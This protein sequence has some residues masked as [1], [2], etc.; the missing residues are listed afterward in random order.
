[1]S[2]STAQ[3]VRSPSAIPASAAEAI[4]MAQDGLRWLTAEPQ[5]LTTAELADTLRGLERVESMLT[6]ARAAVLAAFT[7]RRGFAD[8]GHASPRTWL[9]WQAQVTSGAAAGAVGWM[10]RL[11]AHPAVATA[12]SSGNVSASWAREICAWS[13]LVPE[14]YREASDRILLDAAAG[15]AELAD[16]AGLAAE[17]RARTAE[18]DPGEGN[19]GFDERCLGL[20]R[21]LDGAGRLTGDLTPR[22]AAALAAVLNALGKKGGPEDT[23]TKAQRAHDAL[24]EACRRLIAAGCLPGRAGQP[25][26]IQLHMRLSELRGLPGAGGAEAAWMAGR[27]LS[28][29]SPGDDC[30]AAVAPVVTGSIDRGLLDRLADQLY[31][32]AGRPT[33]AGRGGADVQPETRATPPGTSEHAVS[34]TANERPAADRNSAA[35]S[36]PAADRGIATMRQLILSRAADVLSGPAGLAAYLRRGLLDG[37]AAA[38]SLPLDVGAVTETIPAH[39]RRAVIARDGHCGFPGCLQPAEVC[40]VHHIVPRSEGGTTS[41]TNLKLGCDFHHLIVIHR[42]G[43]KLLMAADGTTTAISPDGRTILRSHGPPASAA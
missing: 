7:A 28:P 3:A 9:R 27:G 21:T 36:N 35:D 32:A 30:D 1:M 24:E 42:W 29:V 5:A 8:D 20:G 41:L 23:R 2:S 13:D 19:D 14:R 39:L 43:W 6:A 16:L 17:I 4:V 33:A 11:A 31:R 25:T 18:P 10:R 12:L 15:G 37:P 38:I 22:C 40:Q 34:P 26:Q